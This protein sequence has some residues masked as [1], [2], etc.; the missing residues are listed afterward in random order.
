MGCAIAVAR[1]YF[2]HI[3]EF[4]EGLKVWG[5]ENIELA[6]RV[7]MCGGRVAT[8]MCSRVGHVFK[9]FPYKFDGDRERIITKN[10]IRVTEA[11]M[12][13]YRKYYYA[14]AFAWDFKRAE[15]NEE[16]LESLAERIELRKRLKCRNFEWYMHNILPEVPTPPDDA[17]LYGEVA[18]LRTKA[19]WEP[20][21]DYYIGMNYLCYE[22]KIMPQNYFYLD[23]LDRLKFGS[24]CVSADPP[25]P[26]LRISECPKDSEDPHRSWKWIMKPRG[27]VW[28]QIALQ[29]LDAAGEVTTEY[30]LIQVTN[31]YLQHLKGAQMPQLGACKDDDDFQLWVWT[32]K[33]DWSQVPDRLLSLD[34]V[35]ADDHFIA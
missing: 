25:Q 35:G 22:H 11:W 15:L 4:D 14:S 13:G 23:K 7:W 21:S 3:G 24:K 1:R 34:G 10:L 32:H 30:C 28:G 17:V 31:I 9:N 18:N 6:F 8:I 19:C 5:G 26:G 16:D 2:E 27:I 12:D 20:T 29:I 33:L